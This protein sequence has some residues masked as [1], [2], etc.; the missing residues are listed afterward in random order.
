MLTGKDGVKAT[1][2]FGF[3]DYVKDRWIE[4]K[5]SCKTRNGVHEEARL[6][7]AR[8]GRLKASGSA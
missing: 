2:V 6:G 4:V 1:R 5:P 3:R 7:I 8:R